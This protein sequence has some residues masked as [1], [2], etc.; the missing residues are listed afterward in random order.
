[1]HVTAKSAVLSFP[2]VRR[3]QIVTAGLEIFPM[4]M[5]KWTHAPRGKRT[6]HAEPDTLF[7]P[8]GAFNLLIPDLLRA[9]ERE[10]YQQ[11][12]PIQEQCIPHILEGRDILGQAQTG[13]GKTAAFAL[14]V[15]QRMVMDRQPL[16]KR[17]PRTLILAPTRELAAQIGDNLKAYARFLTISHTVIFGG[18]NQHSQVQVLRR[19]VDILVATPGRLLDLQRQ[20]ELS[21][22]RVEYFVLDE[23]DRMLDMG[24]LPD[25]RKVLA[26][27]PQQRQTLFFSATMPSDMRKLARDMVHDPISVAITPEK[28]AVDK[29]AQKVMFVEKANKD[30]LLRKLMEDAQIEKAIVF[31]QMKHV[32]NRVAG[33]LGK[34]GTPAAAIHGNKSQAARTRALEGFRKGQF[35]VLVATDVA[36]RGIDV[37]DITHVINY[38]LPMEAETYVHRIGRTARAGAGGNAIS[39]CTSVER[40]DWRR[41]E[42]L[43]GTRVPVDADHAWHNVTVDRSSASNQVTAHSRSRSTHNNPGRPRSRSHHR[44]TF[45][46]AE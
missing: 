41:I 37:D 35:R 40:S 12:T 2:R 1:M 36:A 30:H 29:I 38:D 3:D 44:S 26:L 11:P 45:Q 6:H 25:I 21:L 13:T 15:L 20:G 18:V 19:G 24:F 43:I 39:F 8:G 33:N 4:K 14:P 17:Q 27:I 7:V 46:K 31:T 34:A 32:A 9:V 22:E 10:G 23:V 42:R 16:R 28:P 5:K